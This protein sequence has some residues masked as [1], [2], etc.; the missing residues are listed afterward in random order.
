MNNKLIIILTV[1]AISAITINA[2][3]SSEVSGFLHL[4]KNYFL[5]GETIHFNAYFQQE[6][7]EDKTISILIY[8]EIDQKPDSLIIRHRFKAG[9]TE[10]SGAIEIPI[11]VPPGNYILTAFIEQ[12]GEK[13]NSFYSTSL[14]INNPVKSF[15]PEP[16]EKEVEEHF[17]NI[18]GDQLIPEGNLILNG[19]RNLIVFD[20]LKYAG[21]I[22][23][24]VWIESGNT[25]QVLQ[26]SSRFTHFNLLPDSNQDHYIVIHTK[27]G[28]YYKK[29][30]EISNT[31]IK[32]RLASKEKEAMKFEI[33]GQLE[34]N[35]KY[36]LIISFNNENLHKISVSLDAGIVKRTIPI[37]KLENDKI[38][39]ASLIDSA[40]NSVSNRYFLNDAPPAL[41]QLNLTTGNITP[42][43]KVEYS[44]S[45]ISQFNESINGK[46]SVTV[47]KSQFLTPSS[48]FDYLISSLNGINFGNNWFSDNVSINT[49]LVCFELLQQKDQSVVQI[50]NNGFTPG[51][52]CGNVYENNNPLELGSV[53]MYVN[54]PVVFFER[55]FSGSDGGF[56]FSEKNINRNYNAMFLTYPDQ[57]V[58]HTFLINLPTIDKNTDVSNILT[59]LGKKNQYTDLSSRLFHIQQSYFKEYNQSIK[60][61]ENIDEK[62]FLGEPTYNIRP[63]EY[64]EFTTLPEVIREIIPHTYIRYAN[65]TYIMRIHDKRAE[66]YCCRDNPMIFVNDEPYL[67]IIP[68]MELNPMDIENIEV[69]KALEAIKLLGE[70]GR[71]GILNINLKKGVEMNLNSGQSKQTIKLFGLLENNIVPDYEYTPDF[72]DFREFLYWNGN[73]NS[74]SDE[75]FKFSFNTSLLEGKYTI[76]MIGQTESGELLYKT[77]EFENMN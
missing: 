74:D 26:V 69:H 33:I 55:Y 53:F 17:Q 70:V 13:I 49:K 36:D 31:G 60:T 45:I 44:G 42:G 3:E 32:L 67:D 12:N 1:I 19:Q 48:D 20:L 8:R 41:I 7:E 73:I 39:K 10:A 56:Y 75:G 58:S 76:L 40:G 46:L 16:E 54:E 66:T 23:D 27:F 21:T 2:Q 51:Y 65:G 38:Y 6:L 72:P 61:D 18:S 24:S 14:F 4:N 11:M 62:H 34:S 47:L 68:V 22:V 77:I 50:N 5:S 43:S 28:D 57:D 59:E 64:I 37:R 9:N 29:K 25:K 35:S 30:I 71:N 63:D 52:V 15:S